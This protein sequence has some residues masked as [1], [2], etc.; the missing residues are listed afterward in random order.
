MRNEK[1][2]T[3][4]AESLPAI[5]KARGITQKEAARCIGVTPATLSAYESGIINPSV[6]VLLRISEYYAVSMNRLMS[7]EHLE[8]EAFTTWGDVARTLIRLENVLG[9]FDINGSTEGSAKLTTEIQDS[10]LLDFLKQYRHNQAA[11]RD[12]GGGEDMFTAWVNQAL[13]RLDEL[14]IQDASVN[15]PATPGAEI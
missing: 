14:P 12:F 7:S 3:K 6:N 10:A 13:S 1:V 8:D 5:R 9:Q 4:L 15:E 2:L 11:I